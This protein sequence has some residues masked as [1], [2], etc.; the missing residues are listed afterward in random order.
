MNVRTI[1]LSLVMLLAIPAAVPAAG[2]AQSVPHWSVE[3]KGGYF[4]PDIENWKTFYGD[5][6]TWHYAGSLA[7][8][9]LRQVELGIETGFIRDRGQ[10]YAPLNAITTGS[11][12]YEVVPVNIFVLVRAVFSENQWVVPYAGGGWTRMYYREKIEGQATVRGSVDGYHGRAGLQFL[13][14]G[15]DPRAAHNLSTDFG[16]E[17]TY[18]FGEVQVTKA[19]VG[20]PEV[21]LGG[22]SYLMGFLFEF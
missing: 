13:L 19:T 1:A 12:V 18:L 17:H 11:V 8:K 15:L 16:I 7:Y 3:V 22:T 10:A 2:P 20:T 4:Y 6:K 5:D 21:N 9:I 14:D